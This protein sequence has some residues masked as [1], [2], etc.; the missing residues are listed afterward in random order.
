MGCSAPA[1]Q[2]WRMPSCLTRRQFNALWLA[3]LTAGCTTPPHPRD[4]AAP[5]ARIA[6]GSC[7]RQNRPQPIRTPI[8]DHRPDLFVFFG[9]TVYGDTRTA[10]RRVGKECDSTCR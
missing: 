6:F 3:A 5:I 4:P 9:D 1:P 10:E 8:A 7:A 2:G